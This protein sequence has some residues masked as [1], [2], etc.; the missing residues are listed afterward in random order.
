MLH[1]KIGVCKAV[2]QKLLTTSQGTFYQMG[3]GMLVEQPGFPLE[4]SAY[5]VTENSKNINMIFTATVEHK[6]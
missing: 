4:K 5:T 6:H 1:C 2:M 3:C